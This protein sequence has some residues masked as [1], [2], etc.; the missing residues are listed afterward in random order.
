MDIGRR[1]YDVGECGDLTTVHGDRQCT[2][3]DRSV[4]LDYSQRQPHRSLN[5]LTLNEFVAQ[6]QVKQ[7]VEGVVSSS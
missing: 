3:E 1:M 5:H 2:Y 6:R 4:A 7:A